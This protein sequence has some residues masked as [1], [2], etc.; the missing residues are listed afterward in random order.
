MATG[1]A[2]MHV[3]RVRG[4]L[5]AQ[6]CMPGDVQRLARRGSCWDCSLR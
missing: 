4:L 5:C 2:M 6:G 1:L 3:L